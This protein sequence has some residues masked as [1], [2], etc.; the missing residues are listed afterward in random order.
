MNFPPPTKDSLD[1]RTWR[2]DE[3][4]K[5]VIYFWKVNPEKCS[6]KGYTRA[7]FPIERIT[8]WKLD[9]N[10]SLYL[11]SKAIKNVMKFENFFYKADYKYLLELLKNRLGEN[12]ESPS[13]E[14]HVSFDIYKYWRY[15]DTDI[16]GYNEIET[17]SVEESYYSKRDEYVIRTFNGGIYELRLQSEGTYKDLESMIEKR[18]Q[19]KILQ[20]LLEE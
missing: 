9:E 8:A 3:N 1:Y 14:I 19:T 4:F 2:D 7:P 6:V 15:E 18:S 12:L 17:S 11:K 10:G 20:W 5:N 13:L 16:V